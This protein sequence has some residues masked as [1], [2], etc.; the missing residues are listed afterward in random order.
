MMRL[1]VLLMFGF[2]HFYSVMAQMQEID[3]SFDANQIPHHSRLKFQLRVAQDSVETALENIK[4]DA[5][6][7]IS[8]DSDSALL[9][10]RWLFHES[11][12]HAA[13]QHQE[14]AASAL[15]TLYRMRGQHRLGLAFAK[16]ALQFISP[17]D[18]GSLIDELLI[19]GLSYMNIGEY[20][21]A[22][23]YFKEAYLLS[24]S[25]L[26]DKPNS[27]ANNLGLLYLEMGEYN[28]AARYFF[29]ALGSNHDS[30]TNF[31]R[32]T[33]YHNLAILFV[34]MQDYETA[35]LY[36]DSTLSISGRNDYDRLSVRARIGLAKIFLNKGDLDSAV[37]QVTVLDT[38]I[39][40][41]KDNVSLVKYYQLLADIALRKNNLK[42]ARLHLQSATKYAE[43]IDDL[44]AKVDHKIAIAEMEAK[45]QALDKAAAI[46]QSAEVESGQLP[47]RKEKISGWLANHYAVKGDLQKSNFYFTQQARLRDTLQTQRQARIIYELETQQEQ[48]RKN[49]EINRLT[50]LESEASKKA[51]LRKRLNMALLGLLLGSIIVL[52]F[53]YSNLKKSKLIVD[54]QEILHQQEMLVKEQELDISRSH[55]L[56]EGQESE[57]KRIAADLHD[58]LGTLLAALKLQMQALHD[59]LNLTTENSPLKSLERRIEEAY[60]EVRRISHHMMPRIMAN[61]N[62]TKAIGKLCSSQNYK[63]TGK[64]NYQ[65]VGTPQPLGDAR[66]VMVYRI[67]QELLTNAYKHAQASEI[68]VQISFLDDRVALSVEDNG[69]GFEVGKTEENRTLGLQNISLRVRFLKGNLEID[70]VLG[71]GTEVTID[72]PI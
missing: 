16:F 22:Q 58:G 23:H 69:S 10:Y 32:A 21:S 9:Y 1:M 25:Q 11:G 49:E 70:S 20:D 64:I 24:D 71:E 60:D 18:E 28:F 31:K 50:L 55:A 62:L 57:R 29:E 45:T 61:G 44:K 36:F 19:V 6:A 54:Q 30:V 72:F 15:S 66:E 43:L 12:K 34:E 39:Q 27:A 59:K 8:V 47:E 17:D 3:L 38:K 26:E 4:N 37:N 42:E 2:F 7:L 33:I 51:I 13:L 53:I 63:L 56:V 65:V 48:V 14:M 35:K 68:N 40:S 41:I 67:I 5:R 46:M 52:G